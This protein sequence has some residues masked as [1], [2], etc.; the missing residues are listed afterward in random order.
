M[1]TIKKRNL[2]CPICGK[3]MDR[4]EINT[5]NWICRGCKIT[6]YIRIIRTMLGHDETSDGISDAC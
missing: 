3:V 6:V 2:R 5:E 4:D 1:V